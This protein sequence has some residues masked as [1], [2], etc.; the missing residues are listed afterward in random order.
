MVDWLINVDRNLFLILNGLNNGFFDL[1][2]FWVSDKLIWIPLYLFF[3]FLF[4]KKY[5]IN[6]LWIL[7]AVAILITCSDQLSVLIKNLLQRFR[8]CHDPILQMQVHTVYGKC[9]GKYSFP[10]SHATNF[11]ALVFFIIPFLKSYWKFFPAALILWVSTICY[12]RIYLGVHY[13]GD[14]LAG[15]LLGAFLGW[16]FVKVFLNILPKINQFINKP[17]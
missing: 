15:S 6:T 11:F 10:S 16:I 8:P 13:P 2:M 1:I 3:L 9:G 7:L 4:I 5:K 17:D 14:V 12:S